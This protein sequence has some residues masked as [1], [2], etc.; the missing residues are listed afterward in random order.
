MQAYDCSAS[1][2]RK[3]FSSRSIVHT[4]TTAT[5]RGARWP[6]RLEPVGHGAVG[7]LDL[8][9]NGIRGRIATA[10]A[11]GIVQTCDSSPDRRSTDQSQDD[12]GFVDFNS[13]LVT[14]KRE[15]RAVGS[16]VS[17]PDRG[18]ARPPG[19]TVTAK[20]SFVRVQ[21]C[22][23]TIAAHANEATLINHSDVSAGPAPTNL[24]TT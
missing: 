17:A 20:C 19:T 21:R 11:R 18:S 6:S 22:T 23:I 10:S 13:H 8:Y 9:H 12:C 7:E 2:T 4:P 1:G 14:N 5:G 3:T 15:T 16:C 24:R